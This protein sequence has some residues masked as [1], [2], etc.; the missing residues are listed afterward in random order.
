MS[1]KIFYVYQYLREDG[2]PFYIGKGSKN[3]INDSHLPWIQIPAPEYRQIIKA[4]LTENEAYDLELKIIKKYGRKIDGGI[5][6]NKQI[7]RWSEKAGWKHSEETKRKISE[8]ITGTRKT[9]Q[10]LENY[11]GKKTDTHSKNIKKAVAD[12]WSDP[13]YKEKRLM[14][15]RE[16]PFAHKGKPWS[17]ARRA[18]QLK[19]Q[20]DKGTIK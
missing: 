20:T 19:K 1:W 12:L 6:E 15:I 16:K 13:E 17:P 9:K 4:G 18:A 2:T 10:Q 3:R 7:S 5:L 11:K 14:K 8:A